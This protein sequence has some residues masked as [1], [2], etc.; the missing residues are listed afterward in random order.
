M[1]TVLMACAIALLAAV[2]EAGARNRGSH[3]AESYVPQ[4]SPSVRVKPEAPK[5]QPKTQGGAQMRPNTPSCTSENA[6][7][8]EC[9]A[10]TLQS[11]PVQTIPFKTR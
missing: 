3:G 4:L 11:A 10:S 1:R 5:E 9:S 6:S 7:S 8:P 2:P